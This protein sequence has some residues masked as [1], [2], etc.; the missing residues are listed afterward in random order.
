VSVDSPIVQQAFAEHL[1]A[2][3]PL[4]S[5]FNREAA[6]AFGIYEE[7]LFGL[8]G[9]NQRAVFVIDGE[10]VVRYAWVAEQPAQLPDVREVLDALHRLESR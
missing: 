8:K 9:L 3:F 7:E 2:E 10:G 1:G 6:R 4:L 5:D